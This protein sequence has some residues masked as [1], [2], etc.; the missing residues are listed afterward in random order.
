MVVDNY[1]VQI[2]LLVVIGI[3]FVAS[4]IVGYTLFKRRRAGSKRKSKNY[5]DESQKNSVLLRSDSMQVLSEDYRRKSER[6]IRSNLT[7]E[8]RERDYSMR[9]ITP[10]IG[11]TE[12]SSS[13][14]D[15]K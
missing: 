3:I 8:K 15:N 10:D 4:L 14:R 5:D 9:S 2:V 12:S 1:A 7:Q 13:K 6:F 11:K